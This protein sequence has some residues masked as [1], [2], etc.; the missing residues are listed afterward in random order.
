VPEAVTA[1]EEQDP[2]ARN[3]VAEALITDVADELAFGAAASSGRR[4]LLVADDR[5]FRALASALLS[6]RGYSVSVS[7]HGSD[8]TE[9]AV[10]EAANVVV[11]D[12]SASLTAAAQEAAKLA[13]LTPPV[14]IVAV[15]ANSDA[16]LV[17]LPVVSKWS[18]FEALFG[19]IERACLQIP[20]P[21]VSGVAP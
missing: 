12:A 14:G 13:A 19:A 3:P 17:T 21:G 5:R 6:Q 8:V 1:R 4:V 2:R 9:L 16:G 10:R 7:H 15:S 11:I 20:T 18:P